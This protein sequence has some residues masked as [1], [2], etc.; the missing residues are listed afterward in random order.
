M[1]SYRRWM[2]VSM[3]LALVA[4]GAVVSAQDKQSDK[5]SE[6]AAKTGKLD[7]D[8]IIQSGSQFRFDRQDGGP[9]ARVW[10]GDPDT[11]LFVSSEM[12][13]DGQAIKGAPYSAQA[14]TESIQTLADGNRI[15]H[16][17]TASVYRDG[18]GRT[19]RDQSIGDVAPYATAMGEPSQV[20][21]ISDPVT[22]TH[23]ML[24]P[25]SKTARK[26]TFMFNKTVDGKDVVT[27]QTAPVLV[28][29]QMAE[30]EMKRRI[31]VRSAK[32]D[33]LTENIVGEVGTFNTKV[34]EPKIEQLGKQMIEGV[35][36][37][38]RRATIT[39]PAGEIGNEQPIQIV[40]ESW[41]SPDLK[42]TVMTRQSDPRMGETI[43]RLTNINRAEPAHSL[44]EVP[45]DYTI[46]ESVSPKMKMMIER[47]KQRKPAD[48]Q[49]N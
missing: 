5:Q 45:S 8:V 2:M 23:Y 18:E 3:L 9:G 36:A 25:R 27:V 14:V 12:L 20:V 11:S 4:T 7:R 43:Y 24:D 1:K 30:G 37:E 17:T 15:I 19:R 46:K 39:I 40:S 41:Y 32:G 34:R 6:K 38:G 13:N 10:F 35:E 47:E 48:K 21:S 49:E 29:G 16:R 22:G 33:L 44:F 31:E 42:V 26:M 28:P